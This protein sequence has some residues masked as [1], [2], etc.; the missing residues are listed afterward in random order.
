MFRYGVVL[1]CALVLVAGCGGED[2]GGGG[3]APPG[4]PAG[5]GSGG[6][7][8]PRRGTEL[9]V[10]VRPRGPGGPVRERRVACERLGPAAPE[11]ECRRLTGLTASRLAPVPD[12]VACTQIYGGPATARVTGTIRGRRVDARFSREDGCEIARWERNRALL[13]RPPG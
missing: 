5:P 9:T 6:A 4:G 7:A 12:G 13:G 10:T 1:G 8:T 11:P 2:G 3:A